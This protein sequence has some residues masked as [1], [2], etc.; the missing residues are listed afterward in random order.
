L[1]M[2]GGIFVTDSSY[3]YQYFAD[4][5]K[6]EQTMHI[7]AAKEPPDNDGTDDF[8]KTVTEEKNHG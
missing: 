3:L 2:I 4:K 5:S 6:Q 8:A 1:I 7:C